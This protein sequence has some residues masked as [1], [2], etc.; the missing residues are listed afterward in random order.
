M[1]EMQLD[2]AKFRALCDAVFQSFPSKARDLMD[3]ETNAVWV[4][5]MAHTYRH[6]KQG[7]DGAKQLLQAQ[8]A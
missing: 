6:G 3:M 8:N 2:A 1:L 4:E 5:L 7:V